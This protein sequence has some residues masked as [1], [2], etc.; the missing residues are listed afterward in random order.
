MKL[1]V[2][3]LFTCVV[4]YS[5]LD[6]FHTYFLINFGLTEVNPIMKILMDYLGITEALIVMKT[7]SLTAMLAIIIVTKE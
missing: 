7:I 2:W 1:L 5:V 6:G 3:G 4:F